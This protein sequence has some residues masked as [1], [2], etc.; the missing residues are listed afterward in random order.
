[1]QN[2]HIFNDILKDKSLFNGYLPPF[3]ESNITH[4]SWLRIKD[5]TDR[6]N[7]MYFDIPS[8]TIS[9]L[10]RSKGC[11]YIQISDGYGL[12]HL[13]EDKC[14]FGVPFFETPLEIRIRTKVHTRKNKHGFC[15]LS[16][17]ASCKPKTIKTLAESSCS[18]DE[19]N[20]IPKNLIPF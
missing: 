20:N 18:L 7:D 13:G 19:F 2:H 11:S 6:W 16:V 5:D 8:D 14:E 10:Y 17:I 9:E 3:F 1:M 4:D 15:N 12:Y